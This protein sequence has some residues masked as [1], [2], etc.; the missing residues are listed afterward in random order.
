VSSGEPEK[1]KEGS[2]FFLPPDR[3][4]LVTD[5]SP[6]EGTRAAS[7]QHNRESIAHYLTIVYYYVMGTSFRN[8]YPDRF[9][10]RFLFAYDVLGIFEPTG[11]SP[12]SPERGPRVLQKLAF[13]THGMN[14]GD[15]FDER[16]AGRVVLESYSFDLRGVSRFSWKGCRINHSVGDLEGRHYGY[17]Y[18]KG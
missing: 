7:P 9:D 8:W 15:G 11:L 13:V 2:S 5:N 10:I 3:W 4:S 18:P 12:L 16:L 6:T 17:L 14:N 1:A